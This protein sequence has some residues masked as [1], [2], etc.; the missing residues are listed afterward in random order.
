MTGWDQRP[1]IETPQPF[2]PLPAGLTAAEYYTPGTPADIANHVAAM[3]A[4][5]MAFA[6][7]CPA[8]VGLVYAWNELAEGGWLMPTYTEAGPDRTRVSA[9]GNALQAARLA[10][11]Q[12]NSTT[13]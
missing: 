10:C 8:N 11:V 12:T 13:S 7:A 5:I 9:L 2:Y 4:E 3:T 6:P 1:L